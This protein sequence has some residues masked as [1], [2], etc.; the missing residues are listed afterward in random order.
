MSAFSLTRFTASKPAR[1]SKA[2]RMT[3]GRLV[4]ESG[5]Q[6]F[7]GIAEQITVD[8]AGF[9]DLLVS[10]KPSQALSYG[11]NGHDK[12]RV[13]PVAKLP[14]KP[15]HP[16]TIARDRHHFA[17][18]ANAGVMMLDYDPPPE[19]PTLDPEHLRQ[20]LYGVW[21]GLHAAPHLWRPS[22]GGCI[23]ADDGT[24]LKGVSGQ[25]LYVIV[26]QAADIP[27]AGVVL[28]DR[29]WLAGLGRHEVSKSGALLLRS[30]IDSSVFQP[31]RLDFCGGAECG[32]G[33][34][35]RLHPPLVFNAN[36]E[37]INTTAT[38]RD[39]TPQEAAEVKALREKAATEL[40]G[41]VK[42]RKESW[43]EERVAD[44][45]MSIP[46]ERRHD[47]RPR[48]IDA[49]R[50]ACEDARL[51]ADY[52]LELEKHGTVTVGAILDSPNK[53]H[54]CR[55]LDPLEPDYNGGR[56][57]GWLNLR[58]AGRPYLWSHAHGGKRFTLH[59][60][61]QTIRVIGGELHHMA[62]KALELLRLDGVVYQRGHGLGRLAGDLIQPV[63]PDWLALYL[64]RLCRFEK[65]DK[66]LK[67]WEP[68]D[69]PPRLA[70]SICAMAGEWSLPTLRA[71]V[72]APF[73][74]ADGRIVE[75]DG[76]DAE[77]GLYLDFSDAEHWE[78][79]PLN[80]TLEQIK[81]AIQALWYPFK[82]FPFTGPV[83][84]G[85]FVS[86]IL[87]A[88][89][90]AVLPTAP[91]FSTD[92]PAAGSG[93]SLLAKCLCALAGVPTPEAMPPIKQGDDSEIRKRLF[94][95]CRAGA[96][97][98]LFDNA[99]GNVESPALCAF[100]TAEVFSDRIL[101]VSE[102]GAAPTTA[103]VLFTGNNLSMVGDLNR[104][105]LRAR[106]DAEVEAPHR[107]KFDLNPVAYV[108]EHRL[109]MVRAG[110]I[111]LRGYLQAN[112]VPADSMA[113][114]EAW[115][116]L[117]RGAVIWLG[118][119]TADDEQPF[120]GDPA[121]SIDATYDQDPERAQL[122]AVLDAWYQAFKTKAMTVSEAI[123]EA[124]Q[125]KNINS[126]LYDALQDVAGARGVISNRYLGQWLA[127]MAERIVNGFRLRRGGHDTHKKAVRWRVEIV[128]LRVTAGNCGYSNIPTR[129][130]R[131]NAD[132]YIAVEK[133]PA[134]P[135]TS[136][137]IE[138]DAKNQ[139]DA[140]QPPKPKF[141]R[142][143]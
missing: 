72:S 33:L 50:R 94:A 29:L 9:A 111:V 82:D 121:E 127:S 135:R 138:P 19:G 115:N 54:G 81:A 38:L 13:V 141:R 93:K 112:A 49:Y 125:S 63:C 6:L 80:P 60:A 32:T 91:G 74:L 85:V 110:L 79:I 92:A 42:S 21:P 16:P 97:V 77:S 123:R 140:N 5:G 75:R 86:A 31:E 37:P 22:A 57:T 88:I 67:V 7:D 96:R 61:L 134:Y 130:N 34:V 137:Q 131:K 106:I 108:Q 98:I 17:W 129:E 113:S 142:E 23:Y 39:L 25:R 15:T 2:F 40:A 3:D 132:I 90:R 95:A 46:V 30:I 18:P 27:R 8:P 45:L 14:S 66:R 35:Q 56:Y 10:L 26:A 76:Y 55:T 1:L 48:L 11:V 100:L 64:T 58:T 43:I 104:R 99:T 133:L 102:I 28:F 44:A 114:F 139:D 20:C 68:V 65:F 36:D 105:V 89:Q 41:L 103:M 120:Y 101:G 62:D 4:K 119:L 124:E 136:P 51:L 116:D 24:E 109:A 73:I 118:K 12:A 69:C 107:R 128:N 143:F 59:R 78:T 52:T 126:A 84:R 47:E 87:T 83:D 117:I 122:G 53:Y 71:V 70:S